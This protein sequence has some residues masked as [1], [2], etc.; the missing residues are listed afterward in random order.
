MTIL[1]VMNLLR[2]SAPRR[3]KPLRKSAAS[4]SKSST[5]IFVV[6]G[7]VWAVM[8]LMFFL[9]FNAPS[10]NGERTPWFLLGITIFETG[11]F[12][13]SSLLCLR[14]WKSRQIVSGG[15]VWLWIG[16]GLLSYT[17]GNLLFFLWGNIWNLDPAVSFGDL[18]YIMSYIYLA[19]G[20]FKAVLPRRLNLEPPQWLIVVGLGMGSVLIALF[21]N[22]SVVEAIPAEAAP[23]VIVQVEP[24][25]AEIEAVPAPTPVIESAIDEST[26]LQA[27]PVI[28]SE[29]NEAPELEVSPAIEPELEV[30]SA[31]A[32]AQRLDRELEPLEPYVGALYVMG[33]C[34]LMIIA[35]TLLVAFWGGRYSQSWK[36]IAFGA[37]CLYVADMFFA[38]ATNRGNYVEGDLWEVFW[39][40]SA[41][42]IGLGAVVED[43]ISKKSRRGSRRRR[44]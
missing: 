4:T 3:S 36:L 27:P 34:V 37:F 41:V 38:F 9:L 16:L 31:P 19:A 15:N 35:G 25:P 32:W 5:T 13:A 29:L 21:V 30:S 40:F 10:L 24:T 17:I 2:L 43:A 39:T 22:Y 33:D 44:A 26:T 1:V 6:I 14:N 11:A 12:A 7:I 42:F 20:M 23:I 28:E 18:F 8:A